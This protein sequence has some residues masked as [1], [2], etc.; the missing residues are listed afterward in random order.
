MIR[1]LIRRTALCIGLFRVQGSGFRVQGSGFRVQGAEV[2]VEDAGF[3]VQGSGCRVQGSGCRVQGLRFRF[4]GSGFGLGRGEAAP[5]PPPPLGESHHACKQ[6][7]L[8]TTLLFTGLITGRFGR[9]PP[10]QGHA[11]RSHFDLMRKTVLGNT[12]K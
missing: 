1:V 7:A 9:L 2:K 10:F 6:E 12:F 3:K 4:Q 8:I 5:P 11:N